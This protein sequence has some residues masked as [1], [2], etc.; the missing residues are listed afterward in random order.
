MAVSPNGQTLA[1]SDRGHAVKLWEISSGR[2]IGWLTNNQKLSGSCIFARWSVPATGDTDQ[3]VRLWDVATLQQT[4]QFHGHGSEVTDVDFS[5]D[6]L[7]LASGSK[8]KTA[9]IWNVH[10]TGR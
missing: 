6:G 7:T 9:M 5:A 3:M 10:P 8:D 4:E 1:T 2:E